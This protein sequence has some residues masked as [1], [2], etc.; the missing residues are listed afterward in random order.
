[1]RADNDVGEVERRGEERRREGRSGPAQECGS[2]QTT[3]VIYVPAS[4]RIDVGRLETS[5]FFPYVSIMDGTV[6]LSQGVFVRNRGSLPAAPAVGMP[7]GTPGS[8]LTG[9]A[10]MSGTGVS[11]G[12]G[13]AGGLRVAPDRISASDLLPNPGEKRT[14]SSGCPWPCPLGDMRGRRSWSFC[15]RCSSGMLAGSA[16][17]RLARGRS[18]RRREADILGGAWRRHWPGSSC[19]WRLSWAPPRLAGAC[20]S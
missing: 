11:P 16:S 6:A 20:S 15:D 1:V 5:C 12:A 7:M 14:D 13:Q 3:T 17:I 10:M 2:E 9:G 8:V 18:L 19:S 4:L